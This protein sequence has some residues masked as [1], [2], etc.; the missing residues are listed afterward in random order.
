MTCRHDYRYNIYE[1]FIK[2]SVMNR[3]FGS[4]PWPEKR[5]HNNIWRA[6]KM[7]CLQIQQLSFPLQALIV[8]NYLYQL[9]RAYIPDRRVVATCIMQI[10]RKYLSKYFKFLAGYLFACKHLIQVGVFTIGQKPNFI[11]HP[12]AKHYLSLCSFLSKN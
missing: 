5:L 12:S 4:W 10:F 6:R 11:T 7:L 9:Q 1:L 2:N 8:L 3:P